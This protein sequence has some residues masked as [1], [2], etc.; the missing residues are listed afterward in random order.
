MIAEQKTDARKAGFERRKA[1]H[2]A[3]GD[4]AAS[5]ASANAHLLRYIAN[6]GAGLVI[7]GY[8]PIR[9]EIDV[10]PAMNSLHGLGHRICVPVVVRPGLPLSFR[11]WTPDTQMVNGPFGAQVPSVGD[12]LSPLVLIVPLVAFDDIG[13]RLGYGGG[14]YDRSLELLRKKHPTKAVGFAYSGQKGEVPIEATDQRLDAMVTELGVE[15]FT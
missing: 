14:Y 15:E 7:S 10:L 13:Y 3:C 9:T 5:A 1:A 2:S 4:C 6:Q 8:M 12:W 11:E